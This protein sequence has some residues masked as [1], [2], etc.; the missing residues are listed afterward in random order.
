MKVITILTFSITLLAS[1]VSSQN[2]CNG[3][4]ELCDRLYSNVAH[5]TAHNAYASDPNSLASN[6][7]FDIPTQL[8][9]GIRGFMLDAHYP[10]NSTSE[11]H[12]CHNSCNFDFGKATDI[13]SQFVTWLG[14][15]PNEV[16]TILWENSDKVP[17]A[18]FDQIYTQ[19]GLAKFAH[20]QEPN[21]NDWPSLTSMIESGKRVVNFIDTGADPT[22]VP[23]YIT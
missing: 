19:S 4:T 22:T 9:D 2:A 21:N 14:N 5:V 20:V 12:L 13:L 3:Y 15:N 23:W 18:T 10:D 17:P 1:T 11:V 6:Q 8:K 7:N 16:I